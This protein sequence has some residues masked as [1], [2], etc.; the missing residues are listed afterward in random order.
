MNKFLTDAT[1]R[2]LD[3][4]TYWDTKTPAFGIRIGKHRKTWIV[5]RGKARLQTIVGHYPH[6]PLSD[7]R[8][9]AKKLL[10]ETPDR[11]ACHTWRE[12]KERFIAEHYQD[13]REST[14][15]EAQRLLDK[16][17]SEL[18]GLKLDELTDIHIERE[19]KKLDAKPS[20][21]LHAFRIATCFLKWCIRPPRRFLK[22]NPL[23]G[24]RPPGK[25]G[26]RTRTLSDDELRSVW[27]ACKGR[28]G[29]M[30]RLIILWG[31]RRGETLRLRAQWI[32]DGILTIPG[33][34]TKNGRPHA[35]P[36]LQTAQAVLDEHKN[37]SPYFFPGRFDQTQHFHDGAWDD[38]QRELIKRAGVAPFTAH[39]LRRTFRTLCSR[40]GVSR[41]VAER[42]LNHAQPDLETIYNHHSYIAEKREALSKI[43]AHV[44]SLLVT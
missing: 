12:A 14:R 8:L 27:Q 17:F 26:I 28:H 44:Q 32:S 13:K 19:L 36:L 33:S 31:T 3:P 39:D 4:G 41:E 30:T 22:H 16:H 1:V 40:L 11:I 23:E 2:S 34:V 5:V 18:D 43:E 38:R 10:I 37:G 29:A 6:M 21:K 20:E 42:L 24:Y 15:K 35:I 9:E 7:A 25:D